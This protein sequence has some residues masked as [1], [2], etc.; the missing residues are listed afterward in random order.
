VKVSYCLVWDVEKEKY[1]KKGTVSLKYWME[2]DG[3]VREHDYFYK[4]A[5]QPLKSRVSREYLG[6]LPLKKIEL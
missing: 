3:F 4:I 2:I 6:G 1:A 5:R